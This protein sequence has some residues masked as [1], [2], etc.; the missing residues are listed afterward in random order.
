[1]HQLTTTSHTPFMMVTP[2][3]WNN[4]KNRAVET[5]FRVATHWSNQM[6]TN[7]SFTT[8]LIHTPDS[9]KTLKISHSF[10][11][12]ILINWT[13][14]QTISAVVQREGTAHPAPVA[15]AAP[16]AVAHAAPI[17]VAHA[18]PVAIAHAAPLAHAAPGKSNNSQIKLIG[19]MI[20]F[21]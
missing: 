12:H 1:M 17:A 16:I 20:S 11:S 4:K 14:S 7:V 15:H 10:Q 8:Q 3:M 6:A 13:Y 2:E 18:A 9:S 5:R 21:A 19:I